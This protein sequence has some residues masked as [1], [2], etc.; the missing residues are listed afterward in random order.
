MIMIKES[1]RQDLIIPMK[2]QTHPIL[3]LLLKR[4]NLPRLKKTEALE[5]TVISIHKETPSQEAQE[6][7]GDL[8][9]LGDQGE[10]QDKQELC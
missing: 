10:D 5:V 7:Q 3:R 1:F 6:A 8:G 9:D 4:K 2:N